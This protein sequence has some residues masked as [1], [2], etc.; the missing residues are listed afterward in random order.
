[1]IVDT[2]M[3]I[4]IAMNLLAHNFTKLYLQVRLERP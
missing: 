4:A 1:M 3:L 2:W